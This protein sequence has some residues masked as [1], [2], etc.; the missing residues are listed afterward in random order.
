MDVDGDGR[1]TAAHDYAQRLLAASRGDLG[2]LISSLSDYDRAVAAHVA[3]LCQ[4]SGQSWFT[5]A[6]QLALRG[7]AEEAQAGVRAYLEAWRANQ[8]ARGQR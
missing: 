5:T 7:A 2:K 8:V 6:A 4:A 1:R 3:H